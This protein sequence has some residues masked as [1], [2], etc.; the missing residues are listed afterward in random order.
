MFP[1]SVNP[2]ARKSI[3]ITL[4][5]VLLNAL[6]GF[7]VLLA[8]VTEIFASTNSNLTAIESSLIIT[9]LLIL[10]NLIVYK[11]IDR[12]GR[13]ILYVSSSL[14]TS[15]AHASFAIYLHFYADNV[16]YEWV[17]II[18]VSFI[19]F[20]SSLGMGPVPFIV[21]IEIFPQKVFKSYIFQFIDL[22]INKLRHCIVLYYYR[23]NTTASP[24]TLPCCGR[25]DFVCVK[26]IHRSKRAL[27]YLVG[28]HFSVRSVWAMH[29][30]AYSFYP[31]LV[32]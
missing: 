5:L 21:M 32:D 23:F 10:G 11:L 4:S 19:I 29:C 13:R 20:V 15:L 3:L 6:Q 2:R 16:A 18:S 8:Y 1:I 31:K 22:T 9:S 17:P 14:A 26:H 28:S 7:S 12:A 25:L 24:L 27:D 30:S